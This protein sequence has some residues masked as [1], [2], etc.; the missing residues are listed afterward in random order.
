[1]E[2]LFDETY[3]SND[4]K[5]TS[6]NIWYGY[7]NISIDGEHGKIIK[8]TD[9]VISTL[10][11]IIKNDLSQNITHLPTETNWYFYGNTVNQDAIGENVR[12]VIMVR[13]RDGNF[14]TNFSISDYD[15]AVN[16]DNILL[17]KTNFENILRIMND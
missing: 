16:M 7:A 14:I 3:P 10:C 15:F 1:M 13:E 5:R 2:L 9:D 11:K 17:F 8:L 6:R 12:P 4:G